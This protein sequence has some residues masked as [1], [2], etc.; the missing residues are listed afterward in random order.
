MVLYG[1][2]CRSKNENI[3]YVLNAP[4][5][6]SIDGGKTFAPVRIGHGD[7]HDLRIN[8]NDPDNNRFG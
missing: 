6:R 5:T 4:M 8:P 3:V 7:T 2:V 1:S